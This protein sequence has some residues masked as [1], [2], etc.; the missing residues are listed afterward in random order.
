ML[1]DEASYRALFNEFYN[2]IEEF[3]RVKNLN[4]GELSDLLR[5]YLSEIGRS[6]E[7]G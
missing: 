6:T 1:Y 2:H 5:D 7:E 4:R 3:Y